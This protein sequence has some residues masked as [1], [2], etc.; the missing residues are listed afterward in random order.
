MNEPTNKKLYNSIKKKVISDNPINSAYR[1][2]N[3]VRE[4]KRQFLK[5]NPNKKPYTKD[6]RPKTEGLSRWFKED[7]KNQRGDLGYSKKGDVYRP[8]KRITRDT[9]ITFNE[10]SLKEIRKAQI[11]KRSKGRVKNF[12]KK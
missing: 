3:I 11:E 9:P 2:G 1:S 7:W 8:T 10:L 12:K 5:N 6:A 4:Y